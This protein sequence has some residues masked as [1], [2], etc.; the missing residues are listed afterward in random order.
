[1]LLVVAMLAFAAGCGGDDDEASGT[2]RPPRRRVVTEGGTLVFAG[3]CDPTCSTA[4]SSRTASRFRDHAESSRRSSRSSRARPSPSPALAESWEANEDG[5]VWTFKIRGRA[6]RSTTASRSTP[7]RSASTS[8]A[9]TTSGARSR[10][11]ASYYWQVVFGGFAESTRTAAL[12]RSPLPEL[13]GDR[14]E[15]TAVLTLTKP[16]ATFIPALSLSAFSI[17]SPKALADWGA[18]QGTIDA[19]GVFTRPARRH[20]ASDGHRPVQVRVV[21]RRVGRPDAEPTTTTGARRRSSTRS[22]SGRSPTTPPACRRSRPARS[23]ATTWSSRRTSRRSRATRTCRSSTGRPS[24]SPTSA[25]TIAK[26]P[27][28][29]IKVREAIA[30][31]LEPAG[32]RPTRSTPAAAQVANEFMPPEPRRLRRRRDEVRVQP[33]EG[34]ADPAPSRGLRLPCRSSSGT[35]RTSRVRTCRTRRR[36]F[37]AFA[38]SLSKVGLRGRDDERSVASRLP[39]ATSTR[40]PPATSPDRLDGR[41]RRRGQLH[42]HVLPGRQRPG[43]DERNAAR[44]AS[45]PRRAGDEPGEARAIYQEAN[46]LIM[47]NLP[48][49]PY[50]HSSPALGVQS[51]VQGYVTSPIGNESVR[52][53]LRSRNRRRT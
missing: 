46:R 44:Q 37:E 17:A 10:P 41:L 36:N 31:G 48:G 6:S 5:T 51:D 33:G 11:G 28:N 32:G 23:R 25:S 21:G 42:R 7:R 12:R 34:E 43:F 1:M 4:R 14:R 50:A 9:G 16:S 38:A 3:A 27:M 18:D 19:E 26:P 52:D 20:R 49:V 30:Y 24:T 53:R 39:E 22:S 40:A 2:E 45:R 35:R 8:T 13:R 15:S 29:D 47:Q